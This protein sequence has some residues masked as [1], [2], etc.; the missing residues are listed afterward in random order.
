MPTPMHKP[1][2]EPR[3]V[4]AAPAAPPP[5]IVAPFDGRVAELSV[6]P[7]EIPSPARPLLGI[8]ADSTFEIEVL[9]PSAWLVWLAPG[10]AF[11]FQIDETQRTYTVAVHR[12]GAAVE[13]VSQMVKAIGRVTNHDGT[14][15]S[16]MSGTALFARE[17]R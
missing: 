3:P 17:T 12:L 13:T 8:Y 6:R 9:V 5:R 2:V 15:I 1:A 7:M 11:S 16:G 4:S 14:I 10:T